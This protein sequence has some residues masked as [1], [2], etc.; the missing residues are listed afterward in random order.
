[1]PVQLR[2]AKVRPGNWDTRLQHHC[3]GGVY[4]SGDVLGDASFDRGIL[5]LPALMLW[6]RRHF[7][8]RVPLWLPA[9]IAALTPAFLLFI[10]QCRYYAPAMLFTL[11]LLAA[12]SWT[13][14][15]RRSRLAVLAAGALSTAG[16]WYAS[17]L[18][19]VSALA[20][21]PVFLLDGRYRTRQK[22]FSSV[23]SWPCR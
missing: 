17:Y 6:T 1:V 7:D 2:I 18:N 3:R 8:G 10:R 12:W 11:C 9:L 4:S 22:G 20:M 16:L 23:S 14:S 15:T 19:A 21:L 5:A 13:G